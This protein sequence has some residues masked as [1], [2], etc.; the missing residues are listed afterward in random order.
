MGNIGKTAIG[1]E[2]ALDQL[3]QIGN[4]V[5]NARLLGEIYINGVYFHIEA[6]EVT[7]NAAQ[8]QVGVDEAG[9]QNLAE[10]SAA[11]TPDGGFNTVEWDSREYVL[12]I[13]PGS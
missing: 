9:E 4:P 7:R 5:K 6:I 8:E 13:Y 10:A 2:I 3:E 12:F 11:F 1:I